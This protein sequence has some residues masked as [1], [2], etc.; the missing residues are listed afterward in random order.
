MVDQGWSHPR[1]RVPDPLRILDPSRSWT[2]PD[3]DHPG[4]LTPSRSPDQSGDPLGIMT[5]GTLTTHSS[6][7]HCTVC[8][9]YRGR[10][11]AHASTEQHVG[12]I[13]LQDSPNPSTW[14]WSGVRTPPR[15]RPHGFM[16][17]QIMGTPILWISFLGQCCALRVCLVVNTTHQGR[18]R[19]GYYHVPSLPDQMELS[20]VQR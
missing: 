13:E 11:T 12:V 18:L 7:L 3:L 8:P 16:E 1:S 6:P 14:R 20:S 17:V 19:R 4:I 15:S 9:L 10:D 2:P 5:P